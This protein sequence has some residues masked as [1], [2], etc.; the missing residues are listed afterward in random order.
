VTLVPLITGGSTVLVTGSL[1]PE[2]VARI[3]GV[4]RASTTWD[5]RTSA[6]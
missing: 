2:Q 3:A 6:A 5:S 4:E 1:E